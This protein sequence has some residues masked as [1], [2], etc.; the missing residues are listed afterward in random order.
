MLKHFLSKFEYSLIYRSRIIIAAYRDW[1]PESSRVLDI[2]C[3]NAVV[4]DELR[5]KFKCFI[6]G[7]DA[8]D[9]RKR[10]IPFKMMA[11]KN[12]LPFGDDEFD[13][14]MFNDT[15][16]HCRNQDALLKESL[17]VAAKTLIFEM[18][19]NVISKSLDIL[20][21]QVHN[22]KMDLPLNIKKAQEWR[23]YL[24]GLN[25]DFQFRDIKRPFFNPFKNFAFSIT[26]G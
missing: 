25:F 19:P 6:F 26:K 13:I 5:K 23:D 2:G 10:G 14:C 22:P 16:H 15:L 24:Q 18:E 17:R 9:Y 12:R 4:T 20:I 1:I 8:M 21:N 11:D 7:T 3:G